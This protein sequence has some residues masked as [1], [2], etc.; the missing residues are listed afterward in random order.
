MQ[1]FELCPADTGAVVLD[2]VELPKWT[3]AKWYFKKRGHRGKFLLL[4]VGNYNKNG[5]LIFHRINIK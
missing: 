4:E 1:K 2:E 5:N 3:D